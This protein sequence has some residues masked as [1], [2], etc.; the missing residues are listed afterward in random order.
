MAA[1]PDY[2]LG[3]RAHTVREGLSTEL[4]AF[5]IVDSSGDRSA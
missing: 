3:S 2:R 1:G 4:T 5:G